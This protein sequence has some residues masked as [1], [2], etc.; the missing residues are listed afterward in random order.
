MQ[1][2]R[3]SRHPNSAS[4]ARKREKPRAS[5]LWNR[6]QGSLAA[7]DLCALFFFSQ[8]GAG[9]LTVILQ[10]LTLHRVVLSESSLLIAK[11]QRGQNSSLLPSL[12]VLSIESLDGR[13]GQC[14]LEASP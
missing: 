9:A 12:D 1:W 13:A 4:A 3:S 8:L 2:L 11:G 14:S 10:A 6:A 7:Q 5:S